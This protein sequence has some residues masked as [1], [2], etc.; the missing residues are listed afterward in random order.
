MKKIF[1]TLLILLFPFV[2]NAACTSDEISRL[3]NFASKVNV[4]YDYEE[5]EN[6][7]KFSVTFRNVY[8]DIKIVDRVSGKS[9]SSNNSFSDFTLSDIYIN[10]SYAFNI[11]SNI[12]GCENQLL[13]T[14]YY[15]IP[16]YNR[17]SKDALCD[18]NESKT[19]CQKWLNTSSITYDQFKQLFD[20][21][22]PSIYEPQ[23]IPEPSLLTQLFVNYYYILFG[24]IIIISL[25][26]III[27]NRKDRFNFNT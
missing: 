16:Y 7:V 24:G 25:I 22:D 3:K 5:L 14:K 11:V 8:K 9:F 15:T 6:T 26:I 4:T 2:V 10:G 13:T 20:K 21:K 18:G 23:E 12:K 17:Y 27:L 1:F 19:I